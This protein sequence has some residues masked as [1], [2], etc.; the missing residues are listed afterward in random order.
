MYLNECMSTEPES[1]LYRY[2]RVKARPYLEYFGQGSLYQLIFSSFSISRK[3]I[4]I[5]VLVCAFSLVSCDSGGGSGGSVRTDYIYNN[6]VP[7]PL[8]EGWVEIDYP[9]KLSSYDL[10]SFASSIEL[11]GQALGF[12]TKRLG[13]DCYR[14]DPYSPL[15]TGYSDWKYNTYLSPDI[16]ITDDLGQSI[17]Y[18]SGDW[19]LD[20]NIV[21]WTAKVNLHAEQNIIVIH[22]NYPVI[23]DDEWPYE[24]VFEEVYVKGEYTAQIVVN[25]PP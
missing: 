11:R 9:T 8:E 4:T 1:K 18:A 17:G 10:P 15:C 6:S 24:D 5:L 21:N 19:A 22:V 3:I 13:R 12:R 16:T 25:V 14:T 7:G 20:E 2:L 23:K